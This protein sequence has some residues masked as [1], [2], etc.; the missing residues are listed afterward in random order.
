MLKCGDCTFFKE[1][2]TGTC[3]C[4]HPENYNKA[5]TPGPSF[6]ITQAYEQEC[7]YGYLDIWAARG[8]AK[9]VS[10]QKAPEKHPDRTTTTGLFSQIGLYAAAFGVGLGVSK[11]LKK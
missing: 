5:E 11:I 9:L 10:I 4:S 3:G 1:P 8:A 6:S 7:R 2:E